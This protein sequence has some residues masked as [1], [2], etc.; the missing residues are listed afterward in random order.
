MKTD[1]DHI[2]PKW[3]DGR[4]YMIVCGLDVIFNMCERDRSLNI[5]KSNR[6]VPWR[7]CKDELG[8]VPVEPGDLCLFLTYDT[9]EWVLEEFLGIW[10]WEQSHLWGY[11]GSQPHSDQSK[12]TRRE[13]STRA[14]EEMS[15]QRK[16]ER[17]AKIRQTLTGKP[18]GKHTK[19][20][21]D[22]IGSALRGRPQSEEAKES[23]RQAALR[24]WQRVRDQ[25]KLRQISI[26]DPLT[27]NFDD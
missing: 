4:D 8:D 21:K 20:A 12:E 10:W 18:R 15:G 6:F 24:R 13:A 23:S 11:A 7:W 9:N 17:N 1:I 19:Q 14:W 16:L 26:N 22:K 3:E 5:S 27:P 2:D 25:K